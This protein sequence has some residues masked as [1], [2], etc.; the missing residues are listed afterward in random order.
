M[1]SRDQLLQ[2]IYAVESKIRSSCLGLCQVYNVS[3]DG[4]STAFWT[5]CSSDCLPSCENAFVKTDQ[6]VQLFSIAFC[7]VT[8]YGQESGC[9]Y[10]FHLDR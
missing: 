4:D 1:V 7:P 3:S 5:V 9:F 2:P 6:S 8:M 10:V